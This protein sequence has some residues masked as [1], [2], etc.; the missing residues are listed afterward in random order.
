MNDLVVY[1]SQFGNTE[2]LARVIGS[3]LEPR[4]RVRV[5]ATKDAR[6]LTGED[7]D[8][9]LVGAPT[10]MFGR[11]LL[12][13]SPRRTP[14]RPRSSPAVSRRLAAGLWHRPRASWWPVSPV[15][16]SRVRS[17]APRAG[18]SLWQSDWPS[19]RREP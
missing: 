16:W 7:V 12:V 1:A 10:Q 14:P 4:H 2:R 6:A 18:H 17:S 8:L 9:L 19:P 3:A 13:R 5:V 15:R 11:R